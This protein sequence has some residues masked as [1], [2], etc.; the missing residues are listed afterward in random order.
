ME[1]LSVVIITYNEERNIGR[2]LDSVQKVADEI[3][4]LDSLSTDRTKEI[5]LQRGVRFFEQPFL[6]YIEQKNKALELSANNYV[7][8]LDADEAIDQE[9][10]SSILK[11]KR[12]FAYKGYTMNRC[13][14]YCG[15]FIR[16]GTWYPDR[17]IRLFDKR[18]ALWSGRLI[19]EHVALL[20]LE[21]DS[22]HLKGDILH[23]S[24]YN[25]AEH[26]LQN[27]RYSSISAKA[28]FENG[29]KSNWF[30]LTINPAWAFIRCYLV[31]LGFLDGYYGFVIAKKVAHLTFLKYRKLYA[32]QK[33][34]VE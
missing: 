10:E 13:T 11:A 32:L 30:K 5:C 26:T 14:N 12:Q 27:E 7:L 3:V 9:L 6:G 33:Q 20:S 17:K 23:Y 16:H 2:C 25:I 18:A 24:Y 31:R 4:V 28:Y 21:Y 1:K 8:S 34:K 29:K 15:K 22:C 19:H